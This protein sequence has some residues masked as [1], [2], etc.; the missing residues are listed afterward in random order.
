MFEDYIGNNRVRTMHIPGSSN[1]TD[2]V[3]DPNTN[4][5]FYSSGIGIAKVQ[6][7]APNYEQYVC[8]EK[9]FMY[10][11]AYSMYISFEH[12]GFKQNQL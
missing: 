11:Y 8:V 7:N 5:V 6:F 10:T 3:Y 4:F 12:I 9:V 2:A 1:I